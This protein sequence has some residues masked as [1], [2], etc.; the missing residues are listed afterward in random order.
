[1][2]KTNKSDSQKDVIAEIKEEFKRHTTVLMEHMTKEVRTVAEGHSTV[3]RKLD[4]HDKRFDKVE[5]GLRSVKMAVMDNSHRLD[6]VEKKLDSN[7]DNH[8]KRIT[9]LEEKIH[10]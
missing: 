9:K 5:S 2:K 6:K 1:M 3:I 4:E 10:A 7:L 8:E